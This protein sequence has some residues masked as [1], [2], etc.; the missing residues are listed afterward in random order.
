MRVTSSYTNNNEKYIS[1][2]VQVT[3]TPYSDPS[4][5]T[6]ENTSVTG[7]SGTSANIQILFHG[8]LH[9]PVTQE[10]LLTFFSMILPERI[11]YHHK[12]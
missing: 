5:L 7:T 4:K 2:V 6:T 11:L 8:Q 3:I 1:N 9:F 10:L 12:Q